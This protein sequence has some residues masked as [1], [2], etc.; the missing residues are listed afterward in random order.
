MIGAAF[1]N[2]MLKPDWIIGTSD[3]SG[4]TLEDVADHIVHVCELAGNARHAAIGTDLDGGFGKEQCPSDL[5]TIRDVHNLASILS[6]R[7]FV[8]SDIEAIFY[9]NWLR[10]LRE[11]WGA[12]D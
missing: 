8:E 1:D 4:V 2:W 11:A 12:T 6:K 9:R 10:W 7:G 3:P 5:Q